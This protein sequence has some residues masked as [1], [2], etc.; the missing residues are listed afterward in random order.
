MKK[1]NDHFQQK[2]RDRFGI[3]MAGWEIK[4]L[5]DL[6]EGGKIPTIS[7]YA[8]GASLNYKVNVK[9]KDVIV[10]FNHYRHYLISALIPKYE[11]TGEVPKFQ[12]KLP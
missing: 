3:T 6:I 5:V 1:T 12:P 7:T 2:L 11:N 9:G 10:V 4:Q 8:R